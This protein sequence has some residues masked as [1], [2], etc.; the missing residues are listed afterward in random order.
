LI[1][2]GV[3]ANNPAAY[4]LS[5]VKSREYNYQKPYD[6]KHPLLL[7]SL[8]TGRAH[9]PIA[10]R[11]AWSWGGLRW[12]GPILDI[13]LSDPG[14]E[15]EAEQLMGIFDLYFRLQ[16][17]L[18][19]PAELDDANEKNI[20]ALKKVAEQYIEDNSTTFDKLVTQLKRERPPECKRRV[21]PWE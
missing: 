16:P 14:I 8:G 6:A 5:I 4:A 17:T 19:A 11:E 3:F 9:R 7:L 2:G 18:D 21:G 12:L 15:D 1:D 13:T 10:F 20:K